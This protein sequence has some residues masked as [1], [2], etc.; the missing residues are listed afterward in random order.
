MPYAT[1]IE[2]EISQDTAPQSVIRRR[3][4]SFDSAEE[5]S[6]ERL[7]HVIK[8]VEAECQDIDRCLFDDSCLRVA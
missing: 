7:G 6:L 1:L 8:M 3:P 4:E 5:F 2:E